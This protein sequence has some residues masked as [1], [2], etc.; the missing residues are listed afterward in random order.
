MPYQSDAPA[1]PTNL[2]AAVDAFRAS[3]FMRECLGEVFCDYLAD[4]K[5]AEF[6]RFME[7]VTDWEQREYFSNF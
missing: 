6:A 4:I 7:A 2:G 1:L 5:A 3:A